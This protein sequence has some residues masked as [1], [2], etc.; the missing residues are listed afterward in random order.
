[1]KSFDKEENED[2]EEKNEDINKNNIEEVIK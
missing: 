1:M 2:N